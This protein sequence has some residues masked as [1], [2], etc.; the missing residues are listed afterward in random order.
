[1]LSSQKPCVTFLRTSGLGRG[2]LSFPTV[3]GQCC[4]LPATGFFFCPSALSLGHFQAASKHALLASNTYQLVLGKPGRTM[5]NDNRTQQTGGSMSPTHG[6]MQ[7][8]GA[9]S[10]PSS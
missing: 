6:Q 5:Q 4:A 3:R 7:P 10:S 2:A 1:M 9:S 8:P